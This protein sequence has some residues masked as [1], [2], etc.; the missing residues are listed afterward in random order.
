MG[1]RCLLW[2][3]HRL[4]LYQM[5]ELLLLKNT[6]DAGELWTFGPQNLQCVNAHVLRAVTGFRGCRRVS[7]SPA[8]H[9]WWEWTSNDT[10]RVSVSSSALWIIESLRWE[11]TS[12]INPT[13]PCLL[14]HVLECHIYIYF[15]HLQGWGLR[16]F[17]GESVKDIHISLA[18]GEPWPHRRLKDCLGMCSLGTVSGSGPWRSLQ[19]RPHGTARL[20]AV[21]QL[22]VVMWPVGVECWVRGAEVPLVEDEARKAL[23]GLSCASR[24]EEERIR[25]RKSKVCGWYC[26]H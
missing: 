7:L 22:C 13:P 17:P 25:K 21:L 4:Q 6:G 9:K 14:N 26:W 2:T 1:G 20:W 3:L 23:W 19:G 8:S 18:P 24:R 15:E 5:K 16:R 12:K 10:R 11:K